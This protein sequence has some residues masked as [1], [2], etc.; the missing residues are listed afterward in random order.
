MQE[1]EEVV[2]VLAYDLLAFSQS[3]TMNALQGVLDRLYG[4]T[5]KGREKFPAPPIVF[6]RLMRSKGLRAFEVSRQK[7]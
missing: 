5:K 4:E 7:Q 2:G 6:Y 1:P 3:I